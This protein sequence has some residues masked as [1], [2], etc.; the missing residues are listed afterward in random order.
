MQAMIVLILEYDFRL[1]AFTGQQNDPLS[2]KLPIPD[3]PLH[4]DATRSPKPFL[5]FVRCLRWRAL[6]FIFGGNSHAIRRT[7]KG[8]A[9]EAPVGQAQSSSALL[10]K[11]NVLSDEIWIS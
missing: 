9:T 1:S 10:H 11:S 7:E 4:Y 3:W 6:I 2:A 8:D 5:Q